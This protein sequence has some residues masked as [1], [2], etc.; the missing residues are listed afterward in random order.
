MKYLPDQEIPLNSPNFS[1][2]VDTSIEAYDTNIRGTSEYKEL[3]KNLEKHS[4]YRKSKNQID[5]FRDY[6]ASKSFSECT[7]NLC[8]SYISSAVSFPYAIPTFSSNWESRRT[9]VSLIFPNNIILTLELFDKLSSEASAEQDTDSS[10]IVIF[11]G[12]DI[13]QTVLSEHTLHYKKWQIDRPASPDTPLSTYRCEEVGAGSIGCGTSA[14]INGATQSISFTSSSGPIVTASLFIDNPDTELV[15]DFDTKTRKCI[16]VRP[17][18]TA[19]S[20]AQI[21][22]ELIGTLDE[23]TRSD[24]ETLVYFLSSDQHYIRWDAMRTLIQRCEP[25]VWFSQLQAFADHD[26]HAEVRLAARQTLDLIAQSHIQ[27]EPA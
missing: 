15:M 1:S 10:R 18:K 19:H 5:S 4:S 17:K 24:I 2:H 26:P 25:D 16:A 20:Q 7:L 11:G 3:C 22:I 27:A 14:F 8:K 13:F 9:S 6:I 12:C 23:I 21:F